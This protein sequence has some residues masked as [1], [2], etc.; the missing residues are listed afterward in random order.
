MGRFDPQFT[1][2]V[3]ERFG[4]CRALAAHHIAQ[5]QFE[6][7]EAHRLELFLRRRILPPPDH[8]PVPAPVIKCSRFGGFIP[9]SLQ[10]TYHKPESDALGE[11]DQALA[12]ARF[13]AQRDQSMSIPFTK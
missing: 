7:V 8:V 5:T 9:Q 11:T 12:S 2:H 4:Q 3:E 13:S 6:I 10:K 1:L